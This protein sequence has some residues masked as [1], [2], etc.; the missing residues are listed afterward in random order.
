MSNKSFS[1]ALAQLRCELLHKDKNLKRM[2]EA[3]QSAKNKGADYVI[4]PE[5]FLSGYVM[6]EKLFELAETLDGP[7]ITALAHAARANDIGVIAGFPEKWE[8]YLY[9]AAVCINRH[10]RIVDVYRKTHLFHDEHHYFQA[11]RHCPVLSLPEGQAGMLITY[12]IEFPEMPRLL[13]VNGAEVLF[14]LAANMTPYQA[15]QDTYLHARAMENHV[16][17]AATNKVGLHVENIF[18]GESQVVHPSGTS[19][20]KAGH[21]EELPVIDINLPE[22]GESRGVLDYLNNRR[23]DIYDSH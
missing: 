21:N 11:G 5:L 8:N 20:Y 17:V 13:A 12:D 16:F 1:V 18:F 7:S 22:I 15:Y 2:L 10:G 4:F 6:N 23:R 14:V 9:N 3:I 19:L